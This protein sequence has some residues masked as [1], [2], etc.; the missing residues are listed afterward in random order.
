VKYGLIPEFVGRVPVVASV[1]NLKV[2]DLVRVLKEPK[3]SLLKQYEGL[4]QLNNVSL[5]F[6]QTALK[7]VAEQALGKK[8][9][10]RGLRRIL[11][12]LLLEPMYDTPAS[13]IRQVIIDSKVVGNEKAPVYFTN[14]KS[15]VAEKIISEDDGLTSDEDFPQQMTQI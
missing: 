1:N 12:N 2:E 13:N 4:F 5:R 11:E 14:E 15:H 10:A 3:N 8:T 6:S 7:S 9:G